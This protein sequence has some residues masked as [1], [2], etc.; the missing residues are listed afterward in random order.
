MLIYILTYKRPEVRTLKYIPP[1]WL[2]RTFLVVQSTDHSLDGKYPEIKRLVLPAHIKNVATTRQY[3]LD[4]E[5]DEDGKMLQ[6]DDD[7]TIGVLK[8][9]GK[10]NLRD[11]CPVFDMPDILQRVSNLLDAYPHVGAT[12]RNECHLNFDKVTRE[13]GRAI[14]FHGLNF[15][16]LPDD[17]RFDRV[18]T[19]EDYDFLLQLLRSGRK[20]VLDCQ[21]YVG[22]GGSNAEGGC[23][24]ARAEVRD[25]YYAEMLRSYHPDFVT[26]VE[27]VTGEWK[28]TDVRVQWKKAYES[29]LI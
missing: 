2:D 7:L 8:E 21:T 18:P 5:G 9:Q 24:E 6:L 26:L 10:Y 19:I 11:A 23:S 28:R 1:E 13:C 20:N 4:C 15:R 14:R 12:A 25:G 3:L 29:S 16:L 27:K 22:D 17:I